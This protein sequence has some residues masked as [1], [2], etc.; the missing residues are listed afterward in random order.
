MGGP[1]R[2]GEYELAVQRPVVAGV[3][4]GVPDPVGEMPFVEQPGCGARK[5]RGWV[6]LETD[7]CGRQPVEAYD[8]VGEATA[9]P[10]LAA[11]PRTFY[12]HRRGGSEA[13]GHLL[14]DDPRQITVRS[15]LAH[16]HA[17]DYTVTVPQFVR[18]VYRSLYGDRA[19]VQR[20]WRAVV[21][22]GTSSTTNSHSNVDP[23]T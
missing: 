3:S 15:S 22:T 9:C 17:A 5:E 2:S 16:V 10:S 6:G 19:A 20:V 14:V 13:T 4:H 18:R 12:Y 11:C 23:A 8:A 21:H 7:L 1:D